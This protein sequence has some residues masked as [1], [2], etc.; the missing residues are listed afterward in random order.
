[1]T[2]TIFSFL[3]LAA[4]LLASGPRA[5][6]VLMVLCLFA[7]ASAI[8]LPALGVATITGTAYASLAIYLAA[9]GAIWVGRALTGR[10]FPRTGALL[11][12]GAVSLAAM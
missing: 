6:Y 8:P 12:L 7:A 9:V 4:G 11:V 3:V 1:M 2:P 5:V 10:G